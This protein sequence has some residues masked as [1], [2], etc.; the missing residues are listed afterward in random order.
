LAE[1]KNLLTKPELTHADRQRLKEIEAEVGELPTGETAQE[2]KER[3]EIRKTL[4][5]LMKERRLSQ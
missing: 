4:D 5:L 1:R 3:K 2:G